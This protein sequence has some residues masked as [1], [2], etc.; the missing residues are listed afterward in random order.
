MLGQ[1]F[2]SSLVA[3]QLWSSAGHKQDIY[4]QP[5]AHKSCHMDERTDTASVL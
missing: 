2:I 5:L 4:T 1:D 3:S